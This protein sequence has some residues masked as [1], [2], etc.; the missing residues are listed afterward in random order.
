MTWHGKKVDSTKKNSFGYWVSE[1]Q[2]AL[3]ELPDGKGKKIEKWRRM[4]RMLQLVVG[5]PCV[6]VTLLLCWVRRG[7]MPPTG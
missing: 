4:R 6:L 3:D 1:E 5:V 7:H 2:F